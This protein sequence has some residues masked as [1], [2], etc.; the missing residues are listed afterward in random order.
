MQCDYFFVFFEY[1]IGKLLALAFCFICT[2]VVFSRILLLTC[3]NTSLFSV[4]HMAVFHGREQ[5]VDQV[6]QLTE[7]MQTATQSVIDSK[8]FHGKVSDL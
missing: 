7:Q 1:L 3:K 6:L 8:G 4:L 5:L 2:Y